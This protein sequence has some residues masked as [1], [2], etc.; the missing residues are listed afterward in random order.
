MSGN[1]VSF[2]RYCEVTN[3]SADYYIYVFGYAW[4][5]DGTEI[6]R[7]T[8]YEKNNATGTWTSYLV[9]SWSNI[10]GQTLSYQAPNIPTIAAARVIPSVDSF[11]FTDPVA[12]W[13]YNPISS[14]LPATL[15]LPSAMNCD[16]PEDVDLEITD[17]SA[18]YRRVTITGMTFS[19]NSPWTKLYLHEE[20][21]D[22]TAVN[23]RINT[24][25]SQRP[26]WE[27]AIGFRTAY[28]A[29]WRT[30]YMKD[31]D[32]LTPSL[33]HYGMG[34]FRIDRSLPAGTYKLSDLLATGSAEID[35]GYIH[36]TDT[37]NVWY[38]IK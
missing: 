15:A 2:R 12:T 10:S 16:Y 20:I 1:T 13:K 3:P 28:H 22:G 36:A 24:G 5:T 26:N 11:N 14:G 21:G 19:Q 18:L 6:G 35:S 7:Y 37:P 25:T 29:I 17:R 31:G 8:N 34:G 9:G 27:D 32:S 23:T 33:L 38:T 4:K 30:Y